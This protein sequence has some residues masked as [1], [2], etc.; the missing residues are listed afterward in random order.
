MPQ[1]LSCHLGRNK[2][3]AASV[4]PLSL[5]AKQTQGPES[6]LSWHRPAPCCSEPWS[7]GHVRDGLEGGMALVG[8][9]VTSAAL[10]SLPGGAA[11]EWTCLWNSHHHAVTEERGPPTHLSPRTLASAAYGDRQ[12]ISFH[13]SLGF[14]F[15]RN[16][17]DKPGNKHF[18]LACLGSSVLTGQLGISPLLPSYQWAHICYFIVRQNNNN[19]NNIII[20]FPPGSR[21]SRTGWGHNI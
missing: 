14:L 11:A 3:P 8:G 7:L 2:S 6:H 15:R 20:K 13:R 5:Q 4:Q 10:H 21:G 9:L 16:C 17:E 1:A 18:N 19:N 12:H